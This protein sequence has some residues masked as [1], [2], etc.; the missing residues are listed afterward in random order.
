MIGAA[1]LSA[2]KASAILVNTARG[3]LVDSR[4]LAAALRDGE[5]A[6]AGLDVFEEE[7]EVPPEL[8]A[9]PNAVLL[10]HVGS[11]TTRARDAMA[12]TVARNVLAVLEGREPPDR[13]V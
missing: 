5:I 11:A 2:M 10:P 4:A 1:E 6:A 8:L 12:L 3:S 13:V 9:A 7:P